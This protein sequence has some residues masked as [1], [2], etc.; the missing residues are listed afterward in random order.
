MS[1][2]E[3][4]QA[5]EEAALG[6]LREGRFRKARDLVKP[7]C[8]VDRARFLPLLIE[9]NVGLVREMRGKGLHSEAQQVISFLQTLLPPGEVER[10]VT[11]VP[12]EP[13]PGTA[14]LR[15][16]E[17]LGAATEEGAKAALADELVVHQLGRGPLEEEG[18]GAV[19]LEL[20]L[21]SAAVAALGRAEWEM[22]LG[23][24]RRLAARSPFQGWRLLVRGVA[25][26]HQGDGGKS[27]AALS[28]IMVGTVPARAAVAWL[29]LGEG[30]VWPQPMALPVG[31][32]VLELTGSGGTMEVLAA[33]D[34][35]WRGQRMAVAWRLLRTRW[36]GFPSWEPG[37]T[38][39][40]SNLFLLAVRDL[41]PAVFHKL[42]ETLRAEAARSGTLIPA[43]YMERFQVLSAMIAPDTAEGEGPQW[44]K[45]LKAVRRHFGEKDERGIS[46]GWTMKAERYFIR[47]LYDGLD[48]YEECLPHARIA[49]ERAMQADKGCER[50]WLRMAQLYAEAGKYDVLDGF[51]ERM[52]KQFPQSG[53]VLKLAWGHYRKQGNQPKAA[54][55]LAAWTAVDALAPEVMAAQGDRQMQR[56]GVAVARAAADE[57]LAL[58]AT[59]PPTDEPWLPLVWRAVV[60]ECF[61][62]TRILPEGTSA[63][64]MKQASEQGAWPD[65]L[66]FA[67]A[68]LLTRLHR[69]W[70]NRAVPKTMPRA[71]KPGSLSKTRAF[72]QPGLDRLE[73]LVNFHERYFPGERHGGLFQWVERYAVAAVLAAEMPSWHEFALKHLFNRMMWPYL[74]EA[75]RKRAVKFRREA[76]GINPVIA[77]ALS[78]DR[79]GNE[80]LHRI[81]LELFSRPGL[82]EAWQR[83]YRKVMDA[84]LSDLHGSRNG[85]AGGA[86]MAAAFDDP[87]EFDEME[88]GFD[89]DKVVD[90][91]SFLAAYGQQKTVTDTFR[92][93]SSLSPEMAREFREEAARMGVSPELFEQM[94]VYYGKPRGSNF[95]RSKP[96]K[97]KR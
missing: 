18:A 77:A 84:L 55:A 48:D 38:E 73:V 65:F 45:L 27:K 15:D 11:E 61:S 69:Y 68:V 92:V 13:P 85:D 7:W 10:R 94:V 80:S 59:L 21:V 66:E 1:H 8:K 95:Q 43:G 35:E 50:A 63:E 14:F 60:A 96:K 88:D 25:A 51:L 71:P 33:A 30:G 26:W 39:T 47:S 36:P 76:P 2:L 64:P 17:A 49:L 79:P 32:A 28:Q 12:P 31:Q 37:F 93:F 9:A 86:E 34:G 90:V 41:P 6:Y 74:V 72:F 44:E 91:P 5:D 97:K 87:V 57:A 40:L 4:M 52:I 62:P 83:A 22:A 24:V 29:A 42:M 16:L 58:I 78:R 53:K 82:P 3:Q 46:L 67:G 54:A 70:G 56:L 75:A 89:P 20:N 23:L 19:V 81:R